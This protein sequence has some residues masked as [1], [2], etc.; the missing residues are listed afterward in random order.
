MEKNIHNNHIFEER[1]ERIYIKMELRR[2]VEQYSKLID[3]IE[4]SGQTSFTTKAD[5]ESPSWRK[6]IMKT[7]NKFKTAQ[8]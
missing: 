7:F 6:C 1:A 2:A 3:M 4:S 8:Y 5:E